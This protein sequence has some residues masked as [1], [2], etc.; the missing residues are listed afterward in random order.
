MDEKI[1]L[2]DITEL[3]SSYALP[4]FDCIEQSNQ[5]LKLSTTYLLYGRS[6]TMSPMNERNDSN[7]A[8]RV[9]DIILNAI[10]L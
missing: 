10:S 3:F 8:F 5:S 7:G 4:V 6:L 1:A 2:R 9:G